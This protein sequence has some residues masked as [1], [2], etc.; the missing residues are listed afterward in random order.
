LLATCPKD[1]VRDGN[2]AIKL[3]TKGCELSAWK[4]AGYLST[5][6]AAYAETRQFEEAVKWQKKA[7]DLWYGDDEDREKARQR[8]KLYEAEKPYRDD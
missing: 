7:L 1:S 4:V 8:L 6:A 3:A 5:L 2:K